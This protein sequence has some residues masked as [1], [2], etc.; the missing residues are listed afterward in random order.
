MPKVATSPQLLES[1]DEV[2]RIAMDPQ[3]LSVKKHYCW[4]PEINFHSYHDIQS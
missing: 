4:A 2:D 3:D 1:P